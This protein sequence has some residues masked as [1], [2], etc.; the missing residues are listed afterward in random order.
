[1]SDLKSIQVAARRISPFIRPTPL[2]HS[3]TLSRLSGG[4]VW[5]K[6]ECWQVTG[7]FKPRGA[8]NKVGRLLEMG[9]VRRL[10]T[11]SA[12][13]HGLGVAHAAESWGGVPADIFV[14]ATAPRAKVARLEGFPVTVHQVGKTYER[15][16]RAAVAFARES[17]GIYVPAYDDPDVIAGQ[18]TIG[19]EILA[20]LPEVDW[21][22]VPVGGGGLI[23]GI[24]LAIKSQAP[25][26]Q[27]LGLQP[28]ASPA[29]RLSLRDGRA[30]DPYEHAPTIADGLA[31]GFGAVPFDLAGHLIDDIHLAS[32]EALRRA[33]YTLVDAEQMVVEASGAIAIVPI[34]EGSLDLVGR[35]VVCVLSGRNLAT[36]LLQEILSAAH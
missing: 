5:L 22:L 12:G 26:R 4:E 11:G 1:M 30:H 23:A 19:L 20:E 16:H 36:A 35:T 32:E 25:D 8:L 18:G 14:P 17:G 27:I 21:I 33:I 24:S 13:N 29:A 28:E 3:A 7:S 10:V 9:D 34:I 6:P 2:V 15:A 31:G